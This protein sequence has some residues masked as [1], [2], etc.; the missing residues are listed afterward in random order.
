MNFE[1]QRRTQIV[2]NENCI[3]FIEIRLEKKK[4]KEKRLG[5][6]SFH[7]FKIRLY[8]TNKSFS[9]LKSQFIGL[10][11]IDEADNIEPNKDL[12]TIQDFFF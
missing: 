1:T 11:A 2:N 10:E 8:E 6:A 12:F 9:L 3:I 5:F 7:R 4:E